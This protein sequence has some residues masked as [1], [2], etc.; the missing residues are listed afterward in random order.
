VNGHRGP[1]TGD[2]ERRHRDQPRWLWGLWLG[3][4]ALN[5]GLLLVSVASLNVALIALAGGLA[6]HLIIMLFQ[7]WVARRSEA[8]RGQP[9]MLARALR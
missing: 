2:T 9:C 1:T 6:A 8:A 7:G 3:I 5:V 4:V